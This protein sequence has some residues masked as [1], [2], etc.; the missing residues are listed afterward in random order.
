MLS[1]IY[2]AVVLYAQCTFVLTL[3]CLEGQK[4]FTWLIQ[5]QT[6]NKMKHHVNATLQQ[7][8]RQRLI[9]SSSLQ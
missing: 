8:R 6:L 3:L 1:F 2:I 9:N 4:T 5:E 7:C